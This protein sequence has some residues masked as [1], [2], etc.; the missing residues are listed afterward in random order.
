MV[1]P[2]LIFQYELQRYLLRRHSVIKATTGYLQSGTDS[3]ELAL[4]LQRFVELDQ[5]A[6]L[7]KCGIWNVLLRI[8]R[9]GD[10]AFHNETA[11]DKDSINPLSTSS[12]PREQHPANQS[13]R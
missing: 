3:V 10:F 13:A 8:A 11:R 7:N 9:G 1:P 6:Y 5:P 4:A 12:A 2:S